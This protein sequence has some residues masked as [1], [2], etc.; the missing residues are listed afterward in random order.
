M[1]TAAGQ[2][3]IDKFLISIER[4]VRIYFFFLLKLTLI[5]LEQGNLDNLPPINNCVEKEC[6][7]FSKFWKQSLFIHEIVAAAFIA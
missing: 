7:K 3:R 5:T 6:V 4:H 2:A 1:I